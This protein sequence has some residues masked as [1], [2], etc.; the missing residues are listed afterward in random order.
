MSFPGEAALICIGKA[1]RVHGSQAVSSQVSAREGSGS[2]LPFG[3]GLGC[4]RRESAAGASRWGPHLSAHGCLS[5]CCWALV[6]P[7][8]DKTCCASGSQFVSCI[9]STDL[10]NACLL[11]PVVV[12]TRTFSMKLPLPVVALLI[13]R[14][15]GYS[16]LPFAQ[17]TLVD[18]DLEGDVGAMMAGPARLAFADH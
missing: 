9:G 17:H 12:S 3:C 13:P 15:T 18:L 6:R 16:P 2:K 1:L 8:V 10:C 14:C 4:G 11:T 5:S 7:L